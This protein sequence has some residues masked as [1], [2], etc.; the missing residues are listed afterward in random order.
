MRRA[1]P[2]RWAS[3]FGLERAFLEGWASVSCRNI[4]YDALF[5]DEPDELQESEGSSGSVPRL[6]FE[7]V[8][9]A[10]VAAQKAVIS[11]DDLPTVTSPSLSQRI[12]YWLGRLV[13]AQLLWF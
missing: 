3:V 7:S 6:S 9:P 10:V 12:L 13:R 8:G 5:D 1:L 11:K 2:S 4:D